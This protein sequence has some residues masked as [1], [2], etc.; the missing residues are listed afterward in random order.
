M[1]GDD[2]TERRRRLLQGS[3]ARALCLR[4]ANAM[5]ADPEARQVTVR[6]DLDP[7]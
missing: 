2:P 7:Y 1:D 4:A 5:L 6:I 3:A